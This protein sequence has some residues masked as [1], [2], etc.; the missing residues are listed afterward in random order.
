MSAPTTD[1]DLLSPGAVNNPHVVFAELRELGPVVWS[2]RHRAWITTTFDATRLAFHDTRLSSDR[3]T[4][5]E[6][7]LSDDERTAMGQTF[8]LLRGWMVFHDPPDHDRLREPLRRV[9]TPAR[10]ADLRPR[11]E[12]IVGELLDDVEH[13]LAA[14]GPD[15][16][17]DLVEQFAFPLPA[18]VIAE[19]LGV[20]ADDRDDFKHWSDELAAIVFGTADR[21]RGVER[22]A[23]GSAKFAS[24][25]R[26]LVD[27]YR[28][29][30]ADNLI[31]ALIAVTNDDPDV[32]LTAD[33]L[34]GALTL[35]LFG[36][37]ETTTN[38]ISNS[39]HSLLAHPDQL[40]I[41]RATTRHERATMWEELHRFDGSTKVMVRIVGDDHE[42]GGA[43]METGQTVLLGVLGANRDP[44]I[45]ANPDLLDVEREN[46]R[47]HVGFGSGRHF[48]LGAALARLEA[49]I[50][51]NALVERLDVSRI[52]NPPW[53]PVL[54]GRGLRSLPVQPRTSGV[55]P[56]I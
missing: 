40:D 51:L 17:V 24:Y 33:E 45:F 6:V 14:A 48:C 16:S 54:L 15:G 32:G 30:P 20:P 44:T 7:R 55:R 23:A 53:S 18:I 56:K 28:A 42:R 31:S 47:Q 1:L 36:G 13:Q 12:T 34:V 50:A 49:D 10:V 4:P 27:R 43:S 35:L 9:F 21:K 8:E 26:G 11:I 25:F 3:L 46:A 37:H 29:E 22:A 2:T 38:L 19:L 5:L 52:G 41:V 39:F